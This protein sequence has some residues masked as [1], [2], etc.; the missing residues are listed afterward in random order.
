MRSP[1]LL[2][3]ALVVASAGGCDSAPT[4]PE[5]DARIIS[6]PIVPQ[7]VVT[8]VLGNEFAILN[9]PVLVAIS[10]TLSSIEPPLADAFP[11]PSV[12]LSTLQFLPPFTS[13]L[14]SL[15]LAVLPNLSAR[16]FTLQMNLVDADESALYLLP[17][18]ARD[19]TQ[20][21]RIRAGVLSETPEEFP[22][23][24]LYEGPIQS[25]TAILDLN[26]RRLGLDHGLYRVVLVADGAREAQDLL[27]SACVEG[28]IV[29]SSWEC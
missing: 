25:S 11:Q 1:F 19:G 16:T 22:G 28:Q 26:P 9:G 8:D 10:D 5:G 21:P 18:I 15:E 17:A 4:T 13:P 12:D 29:G 23:L 3:F 27:Y 7:L 24:T 2:S 6:A 20:P 14:G